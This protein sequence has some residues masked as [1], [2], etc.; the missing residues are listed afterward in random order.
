MR[1]PFVSRTTF[2]FVCM[3]RDEER[4]RY[5]DLMEKYHALKLVGGAIAPP[6]KATVHPAAPSDAAIAKQ[7]LTEGAMRELATQLMG[8]HPQLT[9][10]QAEAEAKRLLAIARGEDR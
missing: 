3:Q 8:E 6:Q 9:K 2:N 7:R 1:W 5:A 4:Q 10:P